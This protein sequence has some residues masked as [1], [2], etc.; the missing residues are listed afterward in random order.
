MDK[1][2]QKF[3]KSND[4]TEY[5]VLISMTCS[6]LNIGDL[7]NWGTCVEEELLLDRLGHKSKTRFTFTG[8][9]LDRLFSFL[10]LI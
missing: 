5:L 7:G 10:P 6:G 1:L 3:W 2:L 4:L 8:K 9:Y